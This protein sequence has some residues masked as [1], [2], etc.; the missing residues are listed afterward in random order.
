M[1]YFVTVDGLEVASN[2]TKTQAINIANK[3]YEETKS[4][5][6]VGIGKI[7]YIKGNRMFTCSPMHFY[8]T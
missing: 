4:T 7:K 2:L 5:L 8:S 1:N 3:K 6:R